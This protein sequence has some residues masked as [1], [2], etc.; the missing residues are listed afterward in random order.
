VAT[1]ILVDAG[2]SSDPVEPIHGRVVSGHTHAQQLGCNASTRIGDVQARASRWA[3][4][5]QIGGAQGA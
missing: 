1:A 5:H 2:H 3:Q 4:A